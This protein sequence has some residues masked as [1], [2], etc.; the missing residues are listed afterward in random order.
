MRIISSHCFSDIF[1]I[2]VSSTFHTPAFGTR[3]SSLPRRLTQC[4]T[5]FLL[6]A[7]FPAPGG[8]LLNLLGSLF[9]RV[10]A[11]HH[12]CSCLREQF[13]RRR[14]DAAGTPRNQCCLSRQ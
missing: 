8:F 9:R 10:V 12:V 2:G 5:S 14:A 1:S 13:H 7:C 6:S 4:S 3:M 11:E